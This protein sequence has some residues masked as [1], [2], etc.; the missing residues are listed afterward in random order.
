MYDSVILSLTALSMEIK[1]G[2]II[3][4]KLFK[5]G[6]YLLHVELHLQGF[7]RVWL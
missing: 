7:S 2:T 1:C 4:R 6:P 5:E 3:G